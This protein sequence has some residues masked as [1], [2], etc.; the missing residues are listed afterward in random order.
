MTRSILHHSLQVMVLSPLTL[1]SQGW[2]Q[3]LSLDP[4]LNTS[5]SLKRRQHQM[6]LPHT[7]NQAVWDRATL[8]H[9]K[10]FGARSQIP[11][12]QVSKNKSLSSLG[13]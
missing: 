12:P 3:E 10:L 6:P 2:G 8:H 7:P 4:S 9:L 13:F 11:H 5:L 1:A